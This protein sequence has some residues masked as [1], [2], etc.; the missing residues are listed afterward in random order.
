MPHG[1]PRQTAEAL[2]Q[3]VGVGG[4]AGVDN[5]LPVDFN[6]Q[7]QD[8]AVLHPVGEIVPGQ[9][10]LAFEFLRPIFAQ[11]F[12]EAGVAF[13]IQ[14]IGHVVEAAIERRAR[15]ARCLL[16]ISDADVVE[17]LFPQAIQQSLVDQFGRFLAALVL[18]YVIRRVSFVA[19][20]SGGQCRWIG[21]AMLMARACNACT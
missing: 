1:Q 17:R 16:Q 6:E 7:F 2:L 5:V 8:I 14:H 18:A 20:G 4:V 21:W 19:G 13:P 3:D 10:K 15:Y 12:V 11:Y 9:V